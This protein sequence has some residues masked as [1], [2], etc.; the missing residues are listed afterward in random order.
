MR[1]LKKLQTERFN[2]LNTP[3]AQVKLAEPQRGLQQGRV[4]NR[5]GATNTDW[6]PAKEVF[7][8]KL[9]TTVENWGA[10]EQALAE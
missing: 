1:D 7:G 2:L 6:F 9:K 10:R 8:D 3:G 4:V 5:A